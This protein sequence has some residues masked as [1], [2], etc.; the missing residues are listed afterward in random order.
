[1]ETNSVGVSIPRFRGDRLFET[2]RG[3]AALALRMTAVFAATQA[4]APGTG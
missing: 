3:F 1:M 2:S 4:H